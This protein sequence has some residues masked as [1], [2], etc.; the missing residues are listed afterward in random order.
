MRTRKMN[1]TFSKFKIKGNS[2]VPT[3]LD[4]TFKRTVLMNG[5]I[6]SAIQHCPYRHTKTAAVKSGKGDN[7]QSRE[8]TSQA[9]GQALGKSDYGGQENIGCG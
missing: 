9:H 6:N 4:A 3:K 2:R 8:V 7:S 1:M 5:Q